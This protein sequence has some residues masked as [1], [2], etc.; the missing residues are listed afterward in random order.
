MA[1][2]ATTP[3]PGRAARIIH[4]LVPSRQQIAV[5]LAADA[6]L[7]ALGLPLW[8]HLALTVVFQLT[9]HLVGRLR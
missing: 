8:I 9:I 1:S 3:R 5:G 2:N 6:A 4:W 7:A